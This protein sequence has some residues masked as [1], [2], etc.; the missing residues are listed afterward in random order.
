MSQASGSEQWRRVEALFYEALEC[1]PDSRAAFLD[2]SCAGDT[3]LRREIEELL[4]HTDHTLSELRRPVDDAMA[5]VIPSG[6]I[7]PFRLVRLLGEGGMGAVFLAE[8]ADEEYRQRVAIKLMRAG[9][10]RN[11]DMLRRFRAERQ[12]LADLSHPYIARLL[13]GG[14]TPEGAPYLVMEYI[15]GVAIDRYCDAR[16]LSIDDRVRL[17][18]KVCAAVEYAHLNHIIHRDLKPANILVTNAGDPKLLDFGIAKLLDPDSGEQGQAVTLTGH[19]MTPEYASPEQVR[20]RPLSQAT[21]IYSLGTVLYE[22]IAARHPFRREG[23]SPLE[24]G[25]QISEARPEAPSSAARSLQASGPREI[26]AGLDR[27]VLKAMSKEP[28]E[29]YA[30]AAELADDLRAYLGGAHPRAATGFGFYLGKWLARPAIAAALA[31]VLVAAIAMLAY[32]WLGRNRAAPFNG[33][34][35]SRLTPRGNVTAAAISADGRFVAYALNQ[36]DAQSVWMTQLAANSELRMVAPEAA[37]HTSLSF[38]PDGNFLYYLRKEGATPR[39]L[40]K[41]PIL[42]GAP[43]LVLSDAGRALAFS[44]DG[45]RL[46]FIALDTSRGLASLMLAHQDGA[47]LRALATRQRPAYFASALAWSPDGKYI[48]CFGGGASFFTSN[49]FQLIIVRVADGEQKVLGSKAWPFAGGVAWLNDGRGLIA[50]ASDQLD[51]DFQIW[52]ADYPGGE[53]RRVTN[54]LGNYTNVG[55]TAD[56]QTLVA[57]DSETSEGI[58]V[59]SLKNPASAAPVSPLGLH[60]IGS[61]AWDAHGAVMYTAMVNSTRNVWL[62]DPQS[63]SARQLTSG[64]G[65]KDEMEATPDGRYIVYSYEGK[66]WR[67]DADG[68]NPRQLT[69]GGLDVHASVAPDSRSVVYASFR[70]WSPGIGG[71][72]TLWKIS[73]DGGDPVE[74]LPQPASFPRVSPDGRLIAYLALSGDSPKYVALIPF[75]G[76]NSLKTFDIPAEQIQWSPDSKSLIYNKTDHGIGNLWQQPIQGGPPNQLTAFSA[77]QISEFAVSRDGR[78]VVARGIPL[79]DIVLIRHFR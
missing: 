45:T 1:S 47:G 55:V 58:W 60:G 34:Q 50:S 75:A 62:G 17:F 38:S 49:S 4:A 56:G 24:L 71:N 29:R 32:R 31:L 6:H 42:G 76:G 74:I 23:I 12:I 39:A 10:G 21:D 51:A 79:S 67:M 16:A 61:V 30:T 15:D 40:Y 27:I 9:L 73:I 22:L 57:V 43:R 48:A 66:I 52:L 19:L 36:G 2:R 18:L 68:G 8:R 26:R 53:L 64:P 25:R 7:G 14:T 78:I 69:H 35:M 77:Q 3:A 65:L 54:D 13:H 63:G 41:L 28:A 44:P 37:D 59:S 11:S 5:Q 20:G 33:M 72:P 46:A 70:Q